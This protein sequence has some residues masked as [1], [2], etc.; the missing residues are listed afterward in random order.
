MPNILKTIFFAAFLSAIGL[1]SIAQ[2]NAQKFNPKETYEF[3]WSVIEGYY[4]YREEKSNLLEQV[5]RNYSYIQDEHD[6]NIFLNSAYSMLSSIKEPHLA[7]GPVEGLY[8]ETSNFL[9]ILGADYNCGF[10]FFELPK[11]NRSNNLISREKCYL[12]SLDGINYTNFVFIPSIAKKIYLK[13]REGSTPIDFSKV[14]YYEYRTCSAKFSEK[15]LILKI[16]SFTNGKTY[17]CIKNYLINRK[18]REIILDLRN[19]LGGDE[20]DMLKVL[21]LFREKNNI[22]LHGRD[23]LVRQLIGDRDKAFSGKKIQDNIPLYILVNKDSYSGAEILTL[24]LSS[25]K[26]THIFGE[27]TTGQTEPKL[28][29]NINN[30]LFISLPIA[31][32]VIDGKLLP[33]KQG[34]RP[35]HSVKYL[36]NFLHIN[37]GD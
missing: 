30:V 5:K 10:K 21:S 6:K 24:A 35:T 25:R 1:P 12:T 17:E 2:Q 14:D 37:L 3:L 31:R 28:V 26:N 20:Y 19:N 13:A 36:E 4:V 33:P 9:G 22:E 11:G 7:Y 8:I 16:F 18:S 34:V 23:D 15:F 27:R 29:I 32:S